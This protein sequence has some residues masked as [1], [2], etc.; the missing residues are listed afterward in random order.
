MAPEWRV[1]ADRESLLKAALEVIRQ[2]EAGSGD[3]FSIV[4][5]GGQTPI[6]LYRMLARETMQWEKWHVYFGDERCLPPTDE[7][8]NSFQ[9]T[10]ALLEHVPIPAAHV[11][12]PPAELGPVE[13]ASR[14][15]AQLAKAGRFDLVLLGLGEDG[16]TASLFPG[17]GVDMEESVAHVLPVFDAPKPPA[18]RISLSARRLSQTRMVMFMV[19]GE[20]KREAVRRWRQ[21]DPIPASRIGAQERLLVLADQAAC[22]HGV[23]TKGE[24][25]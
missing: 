4:L 9:A 18:E 12:V 23:M 19:T 14:Y 2:C 13:A 11:H 10:R 1:Y 25:E 8:R 17:H 22:P 6:A 20:S 5:A 3:A 24:Q 21:G 7:G 16:H 15:S